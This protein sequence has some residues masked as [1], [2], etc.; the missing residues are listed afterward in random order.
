MPKYK[1]PLMLLHMLAAAGREA[2]WREEKY[3]A[4][5]REWYERGDGRSSSRGGKGYRYPRCIH[6]ANLWV[7]HDIACGTCESGV[8]LREIHLADAANDYA[9]F[10]RRTEAIKALT[11]MGYGRDGVDTDAIKPLN[12]WAWMPVAYGWDQAM[13]HTLDRQTRMGAW[14][15]AFTDTTPAPIAP[16]MDATEAQAAYDDHW[17]I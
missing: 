6:G 14:R 8:T 3:D 5:V 7:D 15:A 4:D 17:R 9:E 16:D 11:A 13:A 2:A 1:T 10:M 12:E